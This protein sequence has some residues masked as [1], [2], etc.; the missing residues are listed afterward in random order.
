MWKIIA[1]LLIILAGKFYTNLW[2]NV[3]QAPIWEYGVLG[4]VTIVN[5]LLT[6]QKPTLLLVSTL[7]VSTTVVFICDW[8]RTTIVETFP[9]TVLYFCAIFSWICIA[10]FEEE[11][12]IYAGFAIIIVSCAGYVLVPFWKK[13]SKEDW[14]TTLY[15]MNVKS[16][17]FVSL[18][19]LSAIPVDIFI[20][21]LT[22]KNDP[23]KYLIGYGVC[24]LIYCVSGYLQWSIYYAV[25]SIDQRTQMEKW[26][27]E[28]REYMNTIR[29]QRHDFNYHL[30]AIS[31]LVGSENYAECKTYVDQLVQDA[32]EVNEVMPI[33]DAVIGSM[34]LKM[35]EQAKNKG[36]HVDYEIQYNMKDII[37]NGYECNKVIG[38]L[39][40]NALDAIKTEEEKA[41]GVHVQIFKRRGNTVVNV[42]NLFTGDAEQ[43][44]HVF[45]YGFTTKKK[46]SGIGLPNTRRILKRYGGNIHLELKE[47]VVSFVVHIPNVFTLEE[48][49]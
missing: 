29:S 34:L 28:A 7:V 5:E 35:R 17:V 23:W 8:V 11:M 12:F 46:H 3:K 26:Q 24:L 27:T 33:Y 14:M 6:F 20:F 47:P 40:Q 13:I 37:L 48:D 22:H 2:F 25:K 45:E 32:V 1:I 16:Y 30:Q 44:K 10:D 42:S 38:N 39:I 4:S 9:L 41:Y 21:V 31:G 36:T 19:P 49:D 15:Q 43:L 18:L